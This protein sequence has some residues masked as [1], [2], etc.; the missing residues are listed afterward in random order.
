MR[1]LPLISILLVVVVMTI[2]GR[3]A[4]QVKKSDAESQGLK[5][6]V[7]TVVLERAKLLKKGDQF[8]EAA[9]VMATNESFDQQGNSIVLERYLSGAL[10]AKLTFFVL[11]GVRAA[12]MES[13]GRGGAG[14][15]EPGNADPNFTFKY[16]YKYDQQGNRIESSII[17]NHY[18]KTSVTINKYDSQGHLLESK[19]TWYHY[20][21]KPPE[22]VETTTYKINEKGETIQKSQPSYE[23][24][25]SDYKYDVTG[26]W[27][28]RKVKSVSTYDTRVSTDWY[29]EYR[30]ITYHAA[31]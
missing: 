30:T 16:E 11:D 20:N 22:H 23:I 21:T 31:R 10:N 25:Y 15:G 19:E 4:T 24:D 1:K 6:R 2:D 13:F 3:L 26:N 5:G 18:R 29:N 12:K 8:A 7:K 28:S 27:I 9:R 17:N 14:P